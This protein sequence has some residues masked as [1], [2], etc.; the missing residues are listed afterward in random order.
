MNLDIPLWI[1]NLKKDKLIEICTLHHLPCTGTKPQLLERLEKNGI[2]LGDLV[3]P[4]D[5]KPEIPV[6]K[7]I[8]LPTNTSTN[9]PLTLTKVSLLIDLKQSNHALAQNQLYVIANLGH[10]FADIKHLALQELKMCNPTYLFHDHVCERLVIQD[11]QINGHYYSPVFD[12]Q[13]LK[14]YY[15]NSIHFDCRIRL[16]VPNLTVINVQNFNHQFVFCQDDSV[17]L[18]M[19]YIAKR[20]EFSPTSFKYKN[21]IIDCR[22]MIVKVFTDAVNTLTVD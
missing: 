8:T 1:K 4:K 19:Q 17:Q 20:L 6:A 10:N 11:C 12:N 14:D 18:A 7:S 2:T 13:L 16:F 21:Q 3:K 22:Q 15:S 9:V 5:K